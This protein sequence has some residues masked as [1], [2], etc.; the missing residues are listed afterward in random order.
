[1]E[2]APIF[3]FALPALT[4][5]AV[6]MLGSTRRI[7]FWLAVILSIFLTPIGGFIVALMSGP[8]P[9]QRIDRGST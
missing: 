7:G 1:M 8:K 2:L 6:G 3:V 5:L 4:V 9:L